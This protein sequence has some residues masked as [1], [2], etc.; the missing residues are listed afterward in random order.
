[1]THRQGVLSKLE[2]LQT[3]LNITG[4]GQDREPTLRLVEFR[5]L[6][7]VLLRLCHDQRF[8]TRRIASPRCRFMTGVFAPSGT[9]VAQSQC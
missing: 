5:L 8:M 3:A 2:S 6:I 1:M 4:G 9:A 7:S